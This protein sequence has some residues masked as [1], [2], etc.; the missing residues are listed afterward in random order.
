MIGGLGAF[1]SK[2]VRENILPG[3]KSFLL[4]CEECCLI[5]GVVFSQDNGESFLL[6]HLDLSALFLG[7]TTVED[8]GSKF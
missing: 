7:E 3:V 6:N 8:W 2:V 4:E 1:I 5:A